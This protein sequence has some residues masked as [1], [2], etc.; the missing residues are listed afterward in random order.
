[1]TDLTQLFPGRDLKRE[2]KERFGSKEFDAPV[3]VLPWITVDTARLQDFYEKWKGRDHSVFEDEVIEYAFG[4]R[5]CSPDDYWPFVIHHP[6]DL[7]VELQRQLDEERGVS[8]YEHQKGLSTK[9]RIKSLIDLNKDYDPIIDE[10]NYTKLPDRL[11]ETY[12]GEL[13]GQF[14]ATPV[15]ARFVKLMPDQEVGE[16]IDY[17]PKYALKAHIPVYTHPDAVLGFEGHGDIHLVPGHAYVVNTGIKHWAK[18]NS[19]KQRVH[20]VVSLDGQEDITS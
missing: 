8:W 12:I 2:W 7:A 6:T 10:R 17:S 11:N 14:K 20:L 19:R 16:H 3:R 1:M 4:G 15:R 5:Y 13:L 18:N 9:K